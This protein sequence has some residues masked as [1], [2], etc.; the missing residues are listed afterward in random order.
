MK[1]KLQN[2]GFTLVELAI[3]IVIIGVLLVG[4]LQ[5]QEL[6]NQAKI[7]AQASQ[8]QA[9]DAALVTFK[10][11]YDAIPGDI[12]TAKVLMFGFSN[13]DS[14]N[15]GKGNGYINN[16]D[17][18]VPSVN[19]WPEPIFFFVNLSEAKMIKDRLRHID[20]YSAYGINI[21]EAKIDK[22][23]IVAVSDSTKQIFYFLGTTYQA[24]GDNLSYTTSSTVP[25]L[26]TEQ[27]YAL[28]AK[29]DDGLP[30]TGKIFATTSALVADTTASSCITSTTN[31][32]Y[33]LTNTAKACRLIVKTAL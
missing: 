18:S 17:G 33:Y 27:A 21:P 1:Y 3:V 22:G 14:G 11:K 7:R 29:L 23:G 30:S 26:T 6:F 32:T 24:L 28:D 10:G 8:L 31:N 16:Y 4:V 25:M 9:Y 19:L 2:K 5:G 20:N 13:T 12:E 15:A